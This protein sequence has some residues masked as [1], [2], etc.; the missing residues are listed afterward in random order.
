MPF[1]V[2]A[3]AL[4]VVSPL[5]AG[6]AVTML[7]GG[8]PGSIV[9][10]IAD[11][12]PGALPPDQP[13]G[14]EKPAPGAD[15]LDALER[16]QAAAA[17]LHGDTFRNAARWSPAIADLEYFPLRRACF[18]LLVPME[19]AAN[20]SGLPAAAGGVIDIGAA[21]SLTAGS[22]A[23]LSAVHPPLAS[24]R[25]ESRGGM[26]AVARLLNQQVSAVLLSSLEIVPG[27]VVTN[28]VIDGL[29]RI[30]PLNDEALW[31]SADAAGLGYQRRQVTVEDAEGGDP[32]LSDAALCT[33]LGIA[34]SDAASPGISEAIAAAA[35]EKRLSGAPRSLMDR[36]GDL[37][38]VS[39][40]QAAGLLGQASGKAG[41]TAQG[42][43][44]E[45]APRW[46]ARP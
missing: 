22:W 12:V 43:A 17:L 45:I 5:P 20:A 26:R 23:V 21:G 2:L 29:V 19:A 6:A 37:W 7:G 28:A 40:S 38:S 27:D 14:V 8:P 11:A 16:K 39:V 25:T 35:N 13:V 3:A 15:P 36:I 32:K 42:I 41:Q 1:R 4:S 9:E 30:V 34:V 24:V 44:H 18:V 31:R 33:D 46:F 10:A